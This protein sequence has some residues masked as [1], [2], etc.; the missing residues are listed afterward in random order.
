MFSAACQNRM[1]LTWTLLFF[2]KSHVFHPCKKVGALYLKGW[3]SHY[4]AFRLRI[5]AHLL[6]IKEM[7]WLYRERNE[8]FSWF[9]KKELVFGCFLLWPLLTLPVLLFSTLNF[10][11]SSD[12]VV[13]FPHSGIYFNALH[14]FYFQPFNLYVYMLRCPPPQ[15]NNPC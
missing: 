6:T 5:L 7:P 1:L 2:S 3:S 12:R 11:I 8:T 13:V 9:G 10:R 14:S 4:L 15:K